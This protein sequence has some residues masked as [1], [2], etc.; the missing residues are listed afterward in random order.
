[1]LKAFRQYI[2]EPVVMILT[3]F[4]IISL[5]TFVAYPLVSIL[6]T[7]FFENNMFSLRYYAQLLT[8]KALQKIVLQSFIVAATSSTF[9]LIIG[10][11]LAYAL[12]RTD[13]PGKAFL[14]IAA[15]IPLV[16]P[17]YIAALSMILL[18]GPNGL[19]IKTNIYGFWGIVLAQTFSWLP[20]A[21]LM[22]YS[23][24]VSIPKSLEDAGATLGASGSRVFRSITIPLM[25]PALASSFITLFMLNMADFGNPIIIGGGY[26][27]LA[28]R[29]YIEVEGLQRFGMA[30]VLGV[31][32]LAIA[33]PT[34]LLS[35]YAARK[36]YAIITGK[37][38][39]IEPR[40]TKPVIRYT[41]GAFSY[42]IVAFIL[43]IYATVI[44][45]SFTKI[46]G[47][48]FTLTL[49]HYNTLTMGGMGVVWNSFKVAIMAAIITG[50]LGTL[51]AWLLVKK[52]PPLKNFFEYLALT[53]LAIPGTVIG[54]GYVIA[55]NK[56]P[57]LLTGTLWI[58][59]FSIVF[60]EL[61]VAILS[62]EGVL[63][64][65][66]TSL[67]DASASLGA[68]TLRTFTKIVLPLA[69]NGFFSGFVYTFMQG[70]ITLSAVIFLYT[71]RTIL[72]S[73]S[74]IR[75][76]E[77]GR[78]GYACAI[79]TVLIATVLA[80]LIA[81]RI[82]AGKRGLEMFSFGVK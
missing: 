6:Q 19:F 37:P 64:Q 43:L 15:L 55:F 32:L 33:V 36:S 4:M 77:A 51:I 52:N 80:S 68:G 60:R 21:F 41:L 28:T 18:F 10:F 5:L 2:K 62:N 72:A 47:Y 69:R 38:T 42:G 3:I 11:L 59:I 76:A 29:I 22:I 20:V 53:P 23:T 54:L 40:P 71:G 25:T 26:G 57:L 27:V 70:M 1:M 14:S 12:A 81:F 24:F 73:I 75:Q 49:T 66:S 39:R 65:I 48:D 56:P 31:L 35:K 63:K 8:E 74:I 34:Y 61:P 17:P 78:I 79:S 16:A 67:E 7:S 46:W 50:I 82:L 45:G 30:S 9:S 13:I 58:I 44:Y